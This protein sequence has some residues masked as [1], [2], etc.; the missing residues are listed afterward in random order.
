MP[1]WW[2]LHPFNLSFFFAGR[3]HPLRVIKEVA[4][5]L[6]VAKTQKQIVC[7]TFPS[8]SICLLHVFSKSYNSYPDLLAQNLTYEFL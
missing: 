5:L 7:Q 8:C 6:I 1:D 4:E 3:F 2:W